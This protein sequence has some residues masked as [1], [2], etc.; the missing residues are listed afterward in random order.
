VGSQKCK[1]QMQML[2]KEGLSCV[3]MEGE[4]ESNS[5]RFEYE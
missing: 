4:L 5:R 3:Q 2:T 1:G